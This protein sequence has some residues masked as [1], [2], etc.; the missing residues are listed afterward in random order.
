MTLSGVF[1]EQCF[2]DVHSEGNGFESSQSN[3]GH[4]SWMHLGVLVHHEPMQSMQGIN[5][6]CKQP[7]EKDMCVYLIRF[8]QRTKDDQQL[9]SR[10]DNIFEY[11]MVSNE[12][13]GRILQDSHQWS[14]GSPPVHCWLGM[15][16]DQSWKVLAFCSERIL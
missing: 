16:D 7:F 15:N 14:C 11:G 5:L 12:F 6:H 13:Q 4:R 3:F 10:T 8:F 2:V 9:L 1:S